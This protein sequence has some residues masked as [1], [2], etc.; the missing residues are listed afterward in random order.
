[1]K[2]KRPNLTE[3]EWNL[4]QE[5]EQMPEHDIDTADFPEVLEVR[6]PRRG[7]VPLQDSN[8]VVVSLDQDIVSWW[9]SMPDGESKPDRLI[10]EIVR[11]HI[12]REKNSLR[13]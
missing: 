10:N 12:E 8:K 2:K 11:A 5:L 13:S 7:S 3:E 6:N 4:L 1:M 9:E